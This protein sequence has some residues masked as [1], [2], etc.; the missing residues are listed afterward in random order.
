MGAADKISQ[1]EADAIPG[2]FS[3]ALTGEFRIF[4][5]K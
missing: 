5:R 3:E 2:A 1:H 4:F